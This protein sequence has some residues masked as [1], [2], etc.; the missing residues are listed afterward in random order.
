MGFD[1]GTEPTVQVGD[2]FGRQM[3]G[4]QRR[5]Q[6][7]RPQPVVRRVLPRGFLKRV[8]PLSQQRLLD[9]AEAPEV[10][11]FGLRPGVRMQRL[12]HSQRFGDVASL[13]Q[14]MRQQHSHGGGVRLIR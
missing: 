10:A 2:V 14:R 5:E 7:V 1:L 13:H 11:R 4:V 9:A 12:S 8:Q 6:N 3:V